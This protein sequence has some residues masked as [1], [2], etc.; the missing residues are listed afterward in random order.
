M[1][2]GV[3]IKMSWKKNNDN[4]ERESCWKDWERDE[5]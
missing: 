3:T 4:S 2:Q 5:W 1:Y